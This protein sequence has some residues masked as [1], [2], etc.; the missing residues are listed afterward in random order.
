MLFG[1]F[2]FLREFGSLYTKCSSLS[3]VS[4]RF[5]ALRSSPRK[6]KWIVI[7]HEEDDDDEPEEGAM[8]EEEQADGG[9]AAAAAD[10]G[11]RSHAVLEYSTARHVADDT[12]GGCV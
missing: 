10:P 1:Y 12:A 4:E 9:G 3:L 6:S 11:A 7:F 5:A 8:E 2:F